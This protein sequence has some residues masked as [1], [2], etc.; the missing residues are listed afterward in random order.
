MTEFSLI[1]LVQLAALIVAL[2]MIAGARRMFNGMAFGLLALGVLLVVRRLN[3]VFG[4]IGEVELAVV[5][6]L[7]VAVFCWDVW[8]IWKERR[9]HADWLHWREQWAEELKLIRQWQ[10]RK[11]ERDRLERELEEI[12]ALDEG[13]GSWDHQITTAKQTRAIG[14]RQTGK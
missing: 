5:S 9:D 6:S 14:L 2:V 8:R 4:V 12:R 1:Y 11:A 13:V 3:D 10:N 7:V